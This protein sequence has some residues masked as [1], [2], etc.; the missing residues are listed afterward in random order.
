MFDDTHPTPSAFKSDF[1]GSKADNHSESELDTS[2]S[3]DDKS[4]PD[5]SASSGDE[6]DT[7]TGGFLNFP[8]IQ[9]TAMDEDFDKFFDDAEKEVYIPLSESITSLRKKLLGNWQCPK[10]PPGSA[11][12]YQTLTP[13]SF[14]SNIMWHGKSQMGL[15]KH[16]T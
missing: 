5:A 1:H 15:S 12:I 6:S 16:T 4:E 11:P 14:H 13:S 8:S 2:A 3:S 9:D 10:N 7:L